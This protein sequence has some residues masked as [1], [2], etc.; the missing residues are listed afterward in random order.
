MKFDK[1]NKLETPKGFLF[2]GF[3]YQFPKQIVS[4]H[5]HHNNAQLDFVTS[6]SDGTSKSVIIMSWVDQAIHHLIN[7]IMVDEIESHVHHLIV[8][9]I[10]RIWHG[11]HHYG[12]LI[13]TTH[14]PLLFND[15][16]FCRDQLYI[17]DKID[18]A[19]DIAPISSYNGLK[20]TAD[21]LTMY[22]SGQLGSIPD[23]VNIQ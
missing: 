1:I 8:Q 4:E 2:P 19:T 3:A 5:L 9:Q 22:L 20:A 21:I 7:M 23:W 17:V 16:I 6:E 15:K 10:F 12:Q 11:R 13:C 14:D 18:D